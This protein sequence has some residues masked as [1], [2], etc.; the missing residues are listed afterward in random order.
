MKDGCGVFSSNYWQPYFFSNSC[1]DSLSTEKGM[2]AAPWSLSQAVLCLPFVKNGIPLVILTSGILIGSF[3][4]VHSPNCL[5]LLPI[6][7]LFPCGPM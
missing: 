6:W 2:H 7:L 4:L 5:Y 1:A 3:F